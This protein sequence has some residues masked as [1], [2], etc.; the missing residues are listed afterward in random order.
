MPLTDK[1]ILGTAQLGLNYGIADGQDTAGFPDTK[2]RD[3]TRAAVCGE[4][5]I[6]GSI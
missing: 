3:G 6:P 4:G 2:A 5:L 1:L